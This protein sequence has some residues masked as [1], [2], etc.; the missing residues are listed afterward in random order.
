MTNQLINRLQETT[1]SWYTV[2]R[3]VAAN[4]LPNGIFPFSVNVDNGVAAFT[5]YAT[6][7]QNAEDQVNRYMENK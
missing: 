4:W 7:Q 2:M 1:M 6:S 3:D 5:I